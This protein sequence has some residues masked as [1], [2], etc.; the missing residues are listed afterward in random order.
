MGAFS[1]R[2]A[3]AESDEAFGMPCKEHTE[4]LFRQ[5]EGRALTTW[6]K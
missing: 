2:G 3:I 1:E 4:P 6:F 5:P